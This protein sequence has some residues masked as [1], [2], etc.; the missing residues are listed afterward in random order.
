MC[1][2]IVDRAFDLGYA[3][4]VIAVHVGAT[5]IAECP[6]SSIL[7]CSS[8]YTCYRYIILQWTVLHDGILVRVVSTSSRWHYDDATVAASF[9]DGASLGLPS[10]SFAVGW[11]SSS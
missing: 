1:R 8:C 7:V 2:Y 10:A 3:I 9:D 11:A 6:G 5:V 4:D